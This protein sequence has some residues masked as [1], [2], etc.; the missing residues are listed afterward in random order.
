MYKP[1]TSF[2]VEGGVSSGTDKLSIIDAYIYVWHIVI[3]S[4][5]CLVTWPCTAVRRSGNMSNSADSNLWFLWTAVLSNSHQIFRLATRSDSIYSRSYIEVWHGCRK[6]A[7]PKFGLFLFKVSKVFST[8][9][10]YSLNHSWTIYPQE[11]GQHTRCSVFRGE[12][13]LCPWIRTIW[14][15]LAFLGWEMSLQPLALRIA[16]MLHFNWEA[17][18]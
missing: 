5:I 8:L 12:P 1:F 13:L 16:H 7:L 11:K 17:E 10:K 14:Y 18:T 6:K 3:N 4:L 15:F 9:Y 2:P